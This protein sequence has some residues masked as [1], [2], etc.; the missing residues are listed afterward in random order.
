MG[1][2]YTILGRT[3]QPH[4]LSLATIGLAS[5]LVIPN[6]FKKA[7]AKPVWKAA[8]EDEEKFIQEYLEKHS[9]K[10]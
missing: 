5:L 7:E 10:Q 9:A 2:A 3:F 4:Q 8:S 6:P 1:A